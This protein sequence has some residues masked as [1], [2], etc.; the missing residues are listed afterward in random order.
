MESGKYLYDHI[1]NQFFY[2]KLLLKQDYIN[3]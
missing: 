2:T 3:N 1:E